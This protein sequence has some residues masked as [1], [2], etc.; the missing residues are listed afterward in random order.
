MNAKMESEL[1]IFMQSLERVAPGADN[2]QND[3]TTDNPTR[4]TD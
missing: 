4:H 1:I 3:S 2:A